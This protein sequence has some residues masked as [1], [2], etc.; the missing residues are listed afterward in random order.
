MCLATRGFIFGAF[1]V[2]LLRTWAGGCDLLK[3]S[4]SLWY[5]HTCLWSISPLS[6]SL[7]CH[8][9]W[10]L[11]FFVSCAVAVLCAAVL[12]PL[13]YAAHLAEEVFSQPTGL[14]WVSIK[15]AGSALTF[16]CRILLCHTD[17][18]ETPLHAHASLTFRGQV[19]KNELLPSFH[20]ILLLFV[21]IKS[22]HGAFSRL[23]PAYDRKRAG[24]TQRTLKTQFTAASL[25]FTEKAVKPRC[26]VSPLQ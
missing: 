9:C 6:S 18:R 20:F 22:C 11:L 19:C 21:Q 17:Q 1:V 16:C 3:K 8:F 25:Y 13:L 5:L 7:F 15:T 4:R 26:S 23:K 12:F 10:V 14:W 24:G 2:S